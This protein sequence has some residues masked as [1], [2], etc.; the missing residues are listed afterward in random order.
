MTA[1]Q[2]AAKNGMHCFEIAFQ[3]HAAAIATHE[4]SDGAISPLRLAPVSGHVEVVLV[5]L[6]AG[7]D[8]EMTSREIS[9]D[10]LFHITAANG[11][12][13]LYMYFWMTLIEMMVQA[14]QSKG[15]VALREGASQA[16]L[17]EEESQ[18]ALRDETSR[19]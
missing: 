12:L 2:L 17:R 19:R 11:E 15:Q 1:M 14:V 7:R 5:M 4:G 9:F 6:Q 8:L 13:G 16:A 18:A 3:A 10:S